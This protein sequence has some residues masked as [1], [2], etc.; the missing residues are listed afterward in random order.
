M[1]NMECQDA[2]DVMDMAL[3]QCLEPGLR[4]PFDDHMD[5]CAPCRNYFEQLRLTRA[6]LQNLPRHGATSPQ[7]AALI[8]RFKRER[9]PESH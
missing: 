9:D 8:D 2:I 3:E 6:A 5:E 7:R 4:A 1:T